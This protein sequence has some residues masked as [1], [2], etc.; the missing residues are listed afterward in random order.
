MEEEL[1]SSM[2][3]WSKAFFESRHVTQT[4]LHPHQVAADMHCSAQ[5][6]IQGDV[7]TKTSEPLEAEVMVV[8]PETGA[9]KT[10]TAGLSTI[11]TTSKSFR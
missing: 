9:S 3:E 7:S 8:P 5:A 11:A 2:E 1:T 6:T 10:A 4:P